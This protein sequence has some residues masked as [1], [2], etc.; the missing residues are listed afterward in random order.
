MKE[1]HGAERKLARIMLRGEG[2]PA[3]MI[4]VQPNIK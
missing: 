4:Y 1:A 3:N 2:E